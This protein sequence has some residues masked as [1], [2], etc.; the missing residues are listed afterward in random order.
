MTETTEL[1]CNA[2]DCDEL[3][4]KDDDVVWVDTLQGEVYHRECYQ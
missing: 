3:I 2:D 4:T 1:P